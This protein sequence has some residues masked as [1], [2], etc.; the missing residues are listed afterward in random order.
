MKEIKRFTL[1]HKPSWMFFTSIDFFSLWWKESKVDVQCGWKAITVNVYRSGNISA[2]QW[3]LQSRQIVSD[4]A[5]QR[6]LI[7]DY[8]TWLYLPCAV[9][10]MRLRVL[11]QWS[12]SFHTKVTFQL[13][14]ICE[15]K[16][17]TSQRNTVL[18]LVHHRF[19]AVTQ[20]HKYTTSQII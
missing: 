12:I 1:F 2:H 4:Q 3:P 16:S 20:I 14:N 10:C 11:T 15:V 7:T 9:L 13:D 6:C 17:N 5:S 19:A 8:L 18:F